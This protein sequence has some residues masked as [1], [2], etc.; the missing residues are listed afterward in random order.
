[1]P[2][3]ADSEWADVFPSYLNVKDVKFFVSPNKDGKLAWKETTGI[4]SPYVRV[5]MKI[6]FA[7]ERRKQLK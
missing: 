3:G 4:V 2:I 7:N 6:G 5:V 1:L